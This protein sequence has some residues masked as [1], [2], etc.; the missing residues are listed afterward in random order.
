[1][2]HSGFKRFLALIQ[3]GINEWEKLINDM[4]RWSYLNAM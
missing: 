1:M 2:L 3:K 4:W